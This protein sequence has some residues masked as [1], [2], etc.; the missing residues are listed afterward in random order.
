MEVDWALERGETMAHESVA[1]LLEA[2]FR[3]GVSGRNDFEVRYRV[4]S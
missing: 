4:V 2:R 3:P 1:H